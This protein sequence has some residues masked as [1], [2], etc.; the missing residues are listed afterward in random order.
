M[1]TR[2]PDCDLH[3]YFRDPDKARAILDACI[4]HCRSRGA[5]LVRVV[6]GK[7]KGDF[8]NL[9]HSHLLK[10]PDVEEF[11]PCDP[12]HG[13]S[14]ATWVHIAPQ[15]AERADVVEERKTGES[16][17]I[18]NRR[19][20]PPAWRWAVYFAFLVG[21][22]LVFPQW[23]LRGIMMLF[24]FWLEMRIATSRRNE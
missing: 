21:A 10:H 1:S 15:S 16:D 17:E 13:G 18:E 8:R 12:L 11:V 22:F 3:P 7:G 19:P 24:I 9:I 14:G 2:A 6:H 4:G 5:T 23:F 20:A